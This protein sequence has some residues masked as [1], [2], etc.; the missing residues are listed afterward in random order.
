MTEGVETFAKVLILGNFQK[1]KMVITLLNIDGFS[2]FKN[3]E[4]AKNQENLLL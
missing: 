3:W 1:I 4:T 2:K